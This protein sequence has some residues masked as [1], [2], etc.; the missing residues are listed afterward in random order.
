MYNSDTVQS[1]TGGILMTNLRKQVP[2][3]PDNSIRFISLTQGKVATVDA[4]D[5]ELVSRF[6]WHARR[7][8]NTW[9]AKRNPDEQCSHAMMHRLILGITDPCIY[10]DHRD[11]DGLNNTRANLR[12]TTNRQNQWNRR[13]RRGASSKFKGVYWGKRNGKWLAKIKVYGRVKWLGLF[14]DE[15]EAAKAYDTAA[16]EFYGDFASLNFKAEGKR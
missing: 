14:T 16:R 5:Y 2:V 1:D 15:A 12:I 9:Y 11:G 8:H 13:K 7:D 4:A 6:K 10:L 3:P